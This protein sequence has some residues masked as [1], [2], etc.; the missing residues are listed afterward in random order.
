MRKKPRLTEIYRIPE[1]SEDLQETT[2]PMCGTDGAYVGLNAVEC[3]NP[4]CSKFK[5]SKSGATSSSSNKPVKAGKARWVVGIGFD[6]FREGKKSTDDLNNEH[7]IVDIPTKFSDADVKK[8]HDITMDDGA[9][10]DGTFGHTADYIEYFTDV[11]PGTDVIR[12][13]NDEEDDEDTYVDDD[14]DDEDPYP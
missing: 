10:P 2:C 4:K 12:Y 8:A 14:D 9:D 3:P 11:L 13:G 1:S 7:V 6:P 5:A